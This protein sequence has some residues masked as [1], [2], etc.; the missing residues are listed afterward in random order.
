MRGAEARAPEPLRLAVLALAV[1]AGAGVF[2]HS[3]H[4]YGLAAFD[5][6][7]VMEGV[8]LQQTGQMD[9]ERFTHYSVQFQLL[10]WISPDGGPDLEAA[11][12]R[13][14]SRSIASGFSE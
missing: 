5:E 9:F 8:R 12:L 10:A 11:R 3:F 4:D 13:A 14:P 2:F 6:G 1:L 7:I